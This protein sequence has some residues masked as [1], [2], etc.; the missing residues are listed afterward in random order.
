MCMNLAVPVLVILAAS[1]SIFA[2]A[3]YPFPRSGNYAYGIKAT[4]STQVGTQSAYTKWL[5]NYYVE[6]GNYARV[7]F[8]DTTYT[9]S[10]G[11]GYGMLIMVYMDNDAN[12]TQSKFDKLW[13]YYKVNENSDG[14]MN[15]KIQKFTNTCSGNNCNGATDA[16]LDAALA[17]MMAYKQWGDE[18]YLTNAKALI[19]SIYKYE[20]STSKA[21]LLKPGDKWESYYNPSYVSPAALHVFENANTSDWATVLSANYTMLKANLSGSSVLP[22]DWCNATGT[23]VAGNSSIK[24]GYDAVRTPYRIALGYAW[25]GDADAKT[26]DSKIANWEV[27]SSPISG[28][29]ANIVDG[30]SVAGAATGSYNNTTFVGALGAAGMVDSTYQT[31]VNK[32][33]TRLLSTDGTGYYNATLKVLYALLL[34]GNYTN[35]WDTTATSALSILPS[36]AGKGSFAVRQAGSRLLVHAPEGAVS[37]V[38]L[39]DLGGRVRSEAEGRGEFSVNAEGLAQGA[40]VLRLTTGATTLSRTV[41]LAGN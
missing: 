36:K 16:D 13:N 28:V 24:F 35:F 4:N 2:S 8:D 17:L 40:Y 9:V 15:W 7:R 25:Y 34:S 30:Y 12:N 33:W 20:V 11:I 18:T 38:T 3:K 41:V 19:S 22:S 10:E 14:L 23:A 32:S 6:S 39:L 31:W 29:P 37:K 1:S 27:N 5:S 26:I 21:G